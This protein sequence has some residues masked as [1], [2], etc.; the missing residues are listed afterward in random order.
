[1]VHPRPWDVWL[2]Q[3]TAPYCHKERA[4]KSAMDY[5]STP[6]RETPA[7]ESL[8]S[9]AKWMVQCTVSNNKVGEPPR[10]LQSGVMLFRPWDIWIQRA[11]QLQKAGRRF[12]ERRHSRSWSRSGVVAQAQVDQNATGEESEAG[13]PS[14]QQRPWD[15]WIQHG[16]QEKGRDGSDT[17]AIAKF[18]VRGYAEF[19]S[20]QNGLGCLVRG[21]AKFEQFKDGPSYL[22]RGYASFPQFKNGREREFQEGHD[23]ASVRYRAHVS[24]YTF[25]LLGLVWECKEQS[26]VKIRRA[27]ARRRREHKVRGFHYQ[28]RVHDFDHRKRESERE[29][30]G[31]L[32]VFLRAWLPCKKKIIFLLNTAQ[33]PAGIKMWRQLWSK[34]ERPPDYTHRVGK[35]TMY[36]RLMLVDDYGGGSQEGY[37]L[38]DSQ[39]MPWNKTMAY[40][41]TVL[42]AKKVPR[43]ASTNGV[44]AKENE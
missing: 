40:K 26:K 42:G 8:A 4:M 15:M 18:R 19:A 36:S 27:K 16:A 7:T 6:P 20:F 2:E 30:S 25:Y 12:N 38:D 41:E 28:A 44:A 5:N 29:K 43:P 33:L 24:Y 13:P 22:D 34:R 32:F 10:R 1:M 14:S 9:F 21:Y 31:S 17:A 39:N 35:S 11:L 3:I 37:A 23:Q